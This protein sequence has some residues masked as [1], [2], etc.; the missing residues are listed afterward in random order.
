L[1][2]PLA[3]A[4]FVFAANAACLLAGGS[5]N[6]TL[7]TTNGTGKSSDGELCQF[8]LD[9]HQLRS[10]CARVPSCKAENR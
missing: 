8:F 1:L 10:F 6:R 3:G 2:I 7:E 5:G 9:G 4:K